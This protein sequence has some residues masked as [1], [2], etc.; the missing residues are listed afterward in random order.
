MLSCLQNGKRALNR[1]VCVTSYRNV[2]KSSRSNDFSPLVRDILI[3]MLFHSRLTGKSEFVAPLQTESRRLVQDEIDGLA[4]P[5][6]NSKHAYEYEHIR[7]IDFMSDAK[8]PPFPISLPIVALYIVYRTSILSGSPT[9][10]NSW[11]NRLR[12]KLASIWEDDAVYQELEE[13]KDV[14]TGIREFMREVRESKS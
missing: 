5:S 1:R 6:T 14:E 8:L 4:I 3:F 13:W 12:G 2:M 7:Y 9:V 10:I 11:F